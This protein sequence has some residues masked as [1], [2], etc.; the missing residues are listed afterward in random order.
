MSA[1]ITV[2]IGAVLAGLF[3]LGGTVYGARREHA[4]WLRNSRLSAYQAFLTALHTTMLVLF[5]GEPAGSARDTLIS[6]ASAVDL[7]GPPIVAELAQE[8]YTVLAL[9][10]N[11]HDTKARDEEWAKAQDAATAFT[12]QARATLRSSS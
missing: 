11:Q 8:A 3:T 4:Q 1:V 10:S 2:I 12:N 6:T 7:A 5:D 9:W